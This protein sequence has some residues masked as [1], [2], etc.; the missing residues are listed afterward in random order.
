MKKLLP[1]LYELAWKAPENVLFGIAFGLDAGGQT[2]SGV[3]CMAS[4]NSLD[5]E[6]IYGSLC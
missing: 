5:E 2:A 3:S 4:A 1:G 6:R